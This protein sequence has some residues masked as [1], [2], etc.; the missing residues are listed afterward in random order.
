M[1]EVGADVAGVGGEIGL[2]GRG[3]D[4]GGLAQVSG[5]QLLSPGGGCAGID[6]AP[7][8]YEM[9]WRRSGGV[10]TPSRCRHRPV[11]VSNQ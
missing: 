11:A 1:L 5:E 3:Q 2:G 10:T 8:S 7:P 9:S 4:L 6:G